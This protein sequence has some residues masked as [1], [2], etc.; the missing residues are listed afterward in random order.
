MPISQCHNRK[1]KGKTNA[2]HMQNDFHQS[3]Y[4]FFS[5][6]HPNTHTHTLLLRQSIDHRIEQQIKNLNKISVHCRKRIFPQS[7]CHV[8]RALRS[9][10]MQCNCLSVFLHSPTVRVYFYLYKYARNKFGVT[11]YSHNIQEK[12]ICRQ[13]KREKKLVLVFLN[14][15]ISKCINAHRRHTTHTYQIF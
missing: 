8:H 1:R 11:H 12:R 10:K 4:H 13:K 15:H 7:F 14:T 9:I 3:Q 6:I 5:S 2:I